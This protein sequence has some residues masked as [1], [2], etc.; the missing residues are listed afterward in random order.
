[1][2]LI[3][4][5]SGNLNNI[6]KNTVR[7]IGKTRYYEYDSYYYFIIY[8][9]YKDGSKEFKFIISDY[10]NQDMAERQ[11]NNLRNAMVEAMLDTDE[12]IIKPLTTIDL[13]K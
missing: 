10:D 11:C 2:A 3:E 4:D 8:F 12:K 7:L 5:N 6:N 9:F 1:M 13:K